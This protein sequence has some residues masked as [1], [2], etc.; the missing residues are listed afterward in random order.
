MRSIA[1]ALVILVAPAAAHA[2]FTPQPPPGGA[3]APG[4]VQPPG[5]QDAVPGLVH[6]KIV[7]AGPSVQRELRQAR[8]SIERRRENGEL[9][10]G[11]ARSLRREAARVEARQERYARDGISD[12]ELRELELSARTLLYRAQNP[13]ARAPG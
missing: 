7:G 12:H 1:A 10:K 2:Q 9:S 4:I 11:E 5:R 13:A 6:V 8:E 3:R